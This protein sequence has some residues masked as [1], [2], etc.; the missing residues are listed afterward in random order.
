MDSPVIAVKSFP[1]RPIEDAGR[2]NDD[3]QTLEARGAGMAPAAG[4]E[5]GLKLSASASSPREGIYR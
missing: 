2:C 1:S 5:A 4:R 3:P